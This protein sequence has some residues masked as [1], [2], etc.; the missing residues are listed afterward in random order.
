M[1]WKNFVFPI[2][3]RD[4]YLRV[5]ARTCYYCNCVF[6][7]LSQAA[8]GCKVEIMALLPF[9]L[10]TVPKNLWSRWKSFQ[11]QGIYTPCTRTCRSVGAQGVVCMILSPVQQSTFHY[12]ISIPVIKCTM[13]CVTYCEW[14]VDSGHVIGTS[15]ETSELVTTSTG[16]VLYTLSRKFKLQ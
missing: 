12:T 13:R 8:L 9:L 5:T 6:M 7:R 4:P 3:N 1:Y 14:E 16:I 2:N 15:C 11:D 10:S